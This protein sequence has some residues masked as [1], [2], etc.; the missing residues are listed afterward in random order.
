MVNFPWSFYFVVFVSLK[1]YH[2]KS[3]LSPFIVPSKSHVFFLS[4]SIS[5]Q[6][7]DLM[8]Y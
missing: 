8:K 3:L 6:E 2:K 5:E 7:T 1:I 4:H